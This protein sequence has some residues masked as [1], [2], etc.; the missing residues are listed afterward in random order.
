M[1]SKSWKAI[2]IV[3]AVIVVIAVLLF[4]LKFFDSAIPVTNKPLINSNSTDTNPSFGVRK[5]SLKDLDSDTIIEINRSGVV[6]II[7]SDKDI[8][9][10]KILDSQRILSLFNKLSAEDFAK[11]G[12]NYFSD[13]LNLQITI[14]TSRGNKTIDINNDNPNNDPPPD[15]IDDIIDDID[16]IEEVVITPPAS[17]TPT[18][19]ASPTLIPNPPIPTPQAS[20]TPSPIVVGPTPTP[21]PFRCDMLDKLGVTVS[22]IRCLD[23]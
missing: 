18:P 12:A 2:G 16:E 7:G 15:V 5:I 10:R 4:S 8:N 13:F 19:L 20:P 3:V 22:N 21:E 17:P 6:T 1:K 9:H 23:E 14:E 11:L